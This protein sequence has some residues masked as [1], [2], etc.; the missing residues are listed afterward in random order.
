[1]LAG[2][3]SEALLCKQEAVFG[4]AAAGE[5]LGALDRFKKRKVEQQ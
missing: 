3:L 1:M 4:G 2:L 5:Q